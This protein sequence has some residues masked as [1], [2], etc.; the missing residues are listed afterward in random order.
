MVV[1]AIAPNLDALAVLFIL[2][3]DFGLSLDR[4]QVILDVKADVLTKDA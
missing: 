2:R 3:G 4:I 1:A